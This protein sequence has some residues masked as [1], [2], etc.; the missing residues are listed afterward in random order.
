MRLLF[1]LLFSLPVYCDTLDMNYLKEIASNSHN[2]HINRVSLQAHE[3]KTITLG[4][5]T[6]YGAEVYVY[7]SISM[8]C[9]GINNHLVIKTLEPGSEGEKS[10]FHKLELLHHSLL[11]EQVFTF[12]NN[13]EDDTVDGMWYLQL[14][15]KKNRRI[16]CK[17]IHLTVHTRQD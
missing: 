5:I 14:L 9:P 3:H 10:Y 8:E 11:D 17:N 7:A 15:N 2:F 16:E 12:G 13:P 4:E 1:C 6:S